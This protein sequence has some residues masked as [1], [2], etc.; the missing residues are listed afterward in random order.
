MHTDAHLRL[1]KSGR[2]MA[3]ACG[4]SEHPLAAA[5]T[6]TIHAGPHLALPREAEVDVLDDGTLHV[7][8][9]CGYDHHTASGTE[10]PYVLWFVAGA[11]G[12]NPPTA[13]P[14]V[15]DCVTLRPYASAWQG[16]AIPNPN[17]IDT[18]PGSPYPVVTRHWPT[19][20]ISYFINVPIGSTLATDIFFSTP[21]PQIT[22][23][24]QQFS[25][26]VQAIM[27]SVATNPTINIASCILSGLTNTDYDTTPVTFAGNTAQSVPSQGELLWSACAG[28]PTLNGTN[29]FIFL[30]F[31]RLGRS[32]GGLTSMNLD[33]A[34]GNILECDVIFEARSGVPTWGFSPMPNGNLV[35]FSTGL[36]HEI[37]HFFGLDHTNLHPGGPNPVGPA[38]G[39]PA[40][41]AFF[42]TLDA[43]PSMAAGFVPVCPTSRAVAPWTPDDLAGLAAIYPVGSLTAGKRHAINDTGRIR[44]TVISAG[45]GVFGA[46]LF[47]ISRPLGSAPNVAVAAGAPIVGTISGTARLTAAS[48]TGVQDT[49]L[50]LPGSGDFVLEGIPAGNYD[51]V[52]EPLSTLSMVATGPGSPF[53]EWWYDA[54]INPV[55]NLTT[56]LANGPVSRVSGTP[57][58]GGTAIDSL[59]VIA[60]TD[61][62]LNSPIDVGPG[63]ADTVENVSRPLIDIKP[64][65]NVPPP[66]SLVSVTVQHNFSTYVPAG[67]GGPLVPPLAKVA[68]TWNGTPMR[69][70]LVSSTPVPPPGGPG[71][72]LYITTYRFSVPATATLPAIVQASA[73]EMGTGPFGATAVYGFGEVRY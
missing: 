13:G 7:V 40:S 63:A 56:V 12:F 55:N 1:S 64:R 5:F 49:V 31:R 50:T 38:P 66:G 53:G 19:N 58:V 47:L 48:I 16:G 70:T 26:D 11:P 69:L 29:E 41:R 17:N 46:N 20:L 30:Q 23:T 73:I 54:F 44:G 14:D 33:P 25:N 24:Y 15:Y 37:G 59:Q 35:P 18:T 72:G 36:P 32:L 60:G 6:C 68:V 39:A 2:W 42:P 3:T 65:T 67:Q 71:M 57:V 62:Q 21:G 52:P 22:Y 4:T 61:I 43:I 45:A 9:A 10:D 27:N 51:L 28:G 34:T 8:L